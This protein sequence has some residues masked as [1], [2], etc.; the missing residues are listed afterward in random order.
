MNSNSRGTHNKTEIG[1]H[2]IPLNYGVQIITNTFSLTNKR[3]KN[4]Y[5]E[6]YMV[7][8]K[9]FRTAIR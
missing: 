1:L 6:L 8:P 2:L 7:K 9:H 5:L 4:S 3:V